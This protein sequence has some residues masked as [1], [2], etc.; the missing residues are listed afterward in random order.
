MKT[1]DIYLYTFAS[2]FTIGFFVSGYFMRD[3]KDTSTFM[4]GFSETMKNGMILIL[5]YLFGS[6]SSSSKK[7]DTIDTL[8]QKNNVP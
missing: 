6:S 3:V 4:I 2:L 7:D 1:R 5:G 8:S